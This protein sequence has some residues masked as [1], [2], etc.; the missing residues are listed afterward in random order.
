[1]ADEMS[2]SVD[3][4]PE[5]VERA[6]EALLALRPAYRELIGFYSAIFAAQE[7]ARPRVRLTPS[8]LSPEGAVLKQKNQLSLIQASEMR[9]DPEVSRSLFAEL[10][11]IAIEGGSELSGPAGILVAHAAEVPALLQV[12][13]AGD[14]ERLNKAAGDLGAGSEA[15]GFFLYHSL[16]PSLCRCAGELSALLN[17]AIPRDKGS[18]PICGS[19][20]ALGWLDEDGR[21]SL[22]CSFCWHPWPTRR[23]FCPLCGTS[24]PRRLSFLF[25]EEEKEYRVE[26]CGSCRKYLKTVDNRHLNRP[27]YPPLEHIGS[28]HLDIKAAEAGYEP[29]LPLALAVRAA[30]C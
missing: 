1:M 5:Q 19:A 29:A 10:C 16:R 24:D 4:G 27:A 26:L 14:A 23:V 17:E 11:R 21:R 25:S 6:A 3:Y 22:F 7:M 9:F 28:L 20:P 13:L 8:R 2:T 30:S 12:F 15:L 18:C